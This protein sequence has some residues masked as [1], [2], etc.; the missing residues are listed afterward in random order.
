MVKINVEEIAND[1]ISYYSLEGSD[2]ANSFEWAEQEMSSL[3]LF[4]PKKCWEVILKILHQTDNENCLA[5]LA[6]GPFESLLLHHSELMLNLVKIK[7]KEDRKFNKTFSD[8]GELQETI[9]EEEWAE[10]FR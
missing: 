8:S 3:A 6:V 9:T 7:A 4:N 10:I 5:M 1:W 2:Q